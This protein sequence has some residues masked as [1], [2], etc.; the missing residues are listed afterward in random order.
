MRCATRW[1]TLDKLKFYDMVRHDKDALRVIE[2]LQMPMYYWDV[3][4]NDSPYSGWHVVVSAPDVE[5]AR[6]IAFDR[7]SNDYGEQ[8][9]FHLNFDPEKIIDGDGA[10]VIRWSMD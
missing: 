3:T 10:I 6:T 8:A 5:K 2:T 1:T 7:F 4:D 9:V